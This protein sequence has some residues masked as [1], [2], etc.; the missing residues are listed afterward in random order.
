MSQGKGLG[1][2]DMLVQQLTRNR[3][4]KPRTARRRCRRVR[5]LGAS[6][7]RRQRRPAARPAPRHPSA[8]RVE[9]RADA[10]TAR[11]QQARPELGVSPDTLIAQ[12]AL[13][14]GW[15]Q[16]V[17]A[18]AAAAARAQ[19]V[20][21]QGRRVAGAARRVQRDHDR[22]RRRATTEQHGAAISRLRPR[23]PQSVNDYVTLLQRNPRYAG[24]LGTGDR[25]ACVRQRAAARR[26]CHRSG[27]CPKFRPRRDRGRALRQL[28]PHRRSSPGAAADNC[29]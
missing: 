11:P 4:T 10:R 5:H 12:A 27:L 9:L 6:Q 7:Q 29:P 20:R 21:R 1:L 17:P 13:E 19:P 22:V 16:H 18:D 3:A 8:Q 26:L 25:R 24:A 23:V 2:A 28:R 15:G 14:T